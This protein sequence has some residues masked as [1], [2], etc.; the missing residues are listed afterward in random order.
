MSIDAILPRLG[1]RNWIAVVDAAFPEMVAPGITTLAGG[2]LEAVLTSLSEARHVRFDAFLD[3]ELDRL[4]EEDCAGVV[5]FRT[6]LKELLAGNPAFD[7]PHDELIATLFEA[8]KTFRVLVVKTD[9]LIP[10]TSVFLRLEC[11]YW[12]ESAEANL[13]Q[14]LH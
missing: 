4:R 12:T 14:R 13:R 9:L 6:R 8:A 11:G 5:A 1:H 10:Y 2:D 3:S 7:R